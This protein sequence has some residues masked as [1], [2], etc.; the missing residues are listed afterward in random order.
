VPD[1]GENRA[2]SCSQDAVTGLPPV[3]VR[4]HFLGRLQ[5]NKVR[6]LAVGSALAVGRLA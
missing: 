6:A 5:R 1:L 3:G 4:W 2:R